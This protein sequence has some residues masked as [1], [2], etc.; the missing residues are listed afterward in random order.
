MTNRARIGIVLL[1]LSGLGLL[2][3]IIQHVGLTPK[4]P[5]RAPVE[6]R[7]GQT[8]T[9]TETVDPGLFI[10]AVSVFF[11]WVLAGKILSR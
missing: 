4:N 8:A 3:R 5:D 2:T 7:T 9:V 10:L 6:I 1:V 11:G